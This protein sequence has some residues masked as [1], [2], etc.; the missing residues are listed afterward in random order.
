MAE[1]D[2]LALN[3][4]PGLA[5]PA[6]FTFSVT[7]DDLPGGD[8]ANSHFALRLAEALRDLHQEPITEKGFD[9]VVGNQY[10]GSMKPRFPRLGRPEPEVKNGI[11]P[12]GLSYESVWSYPRPPSVGPESRPVLVTVDGERIASSERALRVC[13]TAGA[14]VV[15]IAVDDIVP[16]ALRPA[17]GR[18]SFC[19]W[20]GTASY[21]DVV[22]GG[23]VIPHAVWTYATPSPGFEDLAG[24]YSFYP[25]L[26]ECRLAGEPVRP[27]PGGFYGGWVTDEITGPIKGEPGS[28]GW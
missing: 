9:A 12:N 28:E 8:R 25:G 11:A 22:A 2:T 14:P 17:A 19:E 10:S 16:A 21:F 1:A 4:D 5:F 24:H 18:G 26:V 3:R 6:T 20:K 15:Y 13:E 23:R 27:Q 7:F